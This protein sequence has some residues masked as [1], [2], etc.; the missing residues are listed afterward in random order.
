MRCKVSSLLAVHLCP[1]GALCHSIRL[2]LLPSCCA[3]GG[4]SSSGA[5]SVSIAVAPS[6]GGVPGRCPASP[7]SVSCGGS[8]CGAVRASPTMV[9]SKAKHSSSMR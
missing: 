7:P 8:A 2:R 1:H 5:T 4:A 6:A 3:G 9:V